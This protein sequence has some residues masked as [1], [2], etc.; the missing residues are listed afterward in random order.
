MKVRRLLTAMTLLLAVMLMG[1][2]F[3]SA[4]TPSG[5]EGVWRISQ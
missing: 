3:L 5:L 2:L 1:S 4:H